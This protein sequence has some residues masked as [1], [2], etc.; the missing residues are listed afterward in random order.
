MISP[1]LKKWIKRILITIV[2]LIVIIMVTG[3]VLLVAHK[4]EIQALITGT[5]QDKLSGQLV[6]KKMD[7]TAFESFPNFSIRIDDIFITDSASA[8]RGDTL[9][10]AGKIYV[11]IDLIHLLTGSVQFNSIKLTNASIYLVK[12]STG[13]MNTPQ[14]RKA[15][16]SAAATGEKKQ[17]SIPSMKKITLENVSFHLTDSLKG[18][19]FGLTLKKA[20]FKTEAGEAPM[21]YRMDAD[22]HFDGLVFNPVKGGYLTDQDIHLNTSIGFDAAKSLLIVTDGL[23]NLNKQYLLI[24][25]KMNFK[26][27]TMQMRF[28]A[29]S[30]LPAVAYKALTPA[31]YEKL[32][33]FQLEKPV[34]ARVLV[35]GFITPGSKPAVDVYFKTIGNTLSVKTRTFEN[36]EIIGWFTS[37]VDSTKINDDHNSRVMLPVFRGTNFGLPLVATVS[38][39][40]LLDPML[41]MN[42]HL[43]YDSKVNGVTTTKYF[44]FSNGEIDIRYFFHGPLMN[45]V[46]TVNRVL[47]GDLSGEISMKHAE[48]D[49]RNTGYQYRDVN[50]HL[51]FKKPNLIIDSIGMSMNGNRMKLKGSVQYS[52][53]AL[54]IPEVKALAILDLSADT[55]DFN[56]FKVPPSVAQQKKSM[57]SK[58]DGRKSN[59]ADIPD[60][61]N[62]MA[63]NLECNINLSAKK[64]IIQKF[65]GADIKANVVLGNNMLQINDAGMN[66]SGGSFLLNM[67]IGNLSANQHP[68]RLKTS[69]KGV[70]MS[71]LMYSFNNFG[72]TA[73]TNKNISGT[74]TCTASLSASIDKNY[75]VVGSSMNGDLRTKVKN[76]TLKNVEALEKIT[77]YIFKNRDFSNIEFADIDNRSKLTGTVL[78]IDT[79]NIFS[80]VITLFISGTYD[81]SKSNTDM[82]IT[83]PFSNLKKMES[84]ERMALSDSAAR[85]GGNLT[86]RA[87]NGKDGELKIAPVIFGKKK[88]QDKEA[89][90]G[91]EAKAAKEKKK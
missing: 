39:T 10:K 84:S 13:R 82:L 69:I 26:D 28:D 52:I 11:G 65:S 49:Q 59:Q 71:D 66:T 79:L 57:G 91:K 29:S 86:L 18:K 74:L 58:E 21:S 45:M 34:I 75:N 9:F 30:I 40:D 2:S 42:A 90:P 72:Q 27:K 6:M 48:F 35:K 68:L 76:G 89:K 25:A 61:V 47:I 16:S 83:V 36:L 14:A 56:S 70:R 7:F 46:D 19:K 5:F 43:R 24:N 60:L 17:A 22:I 73:I 15:P 51:S 44:Q 62:Y 80:S 78:D 54:L 12:D 32:K 20:E 33:G 23:L 53:A 37:H 4:K 41:V 31:I 55:I 64:V 8:L 77:K 3:Y 88:D 1:K 50:G 63:S 67:S 81:F 87:S 38:V 85:K